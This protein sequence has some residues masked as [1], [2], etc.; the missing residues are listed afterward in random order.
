MSEFQKHLYLILHPNEAL[1]A[2]Q[3]SPE[4][5]GSH[6]SIGSPRHFTG[7]VIFAEIDINYREEFLRIDED[8][9]A[10]RVRDSGQAEA[11]EVR[12]VVPGDG[13]HRS[14]GTA[15]AVPRDD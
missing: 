11:D 13:A 7:K 2:S 4:E 15:E 3:L 1:V 6:Y 14:R 12:E 10:D 5:F 9:G 8:P